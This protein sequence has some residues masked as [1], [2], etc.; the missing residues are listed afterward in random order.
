MQT[1]FKYPEE[2]RDFQFDFGSQPEIEQEFDSLTGT[3][4]LAQSLRSGSGA[5]TIGAPSIVSGQPVVQARI[6]GGVLSSSYELLCT[7]Q[8]AAGRTLA[9]N[10]VLLIKRDS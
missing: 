2:I 9:V 1:L 7:V 4:V 5:V 6:S 10:G 8:T 3:P